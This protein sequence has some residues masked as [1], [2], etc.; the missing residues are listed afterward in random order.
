MG[1]HLHLP[2]TDKLKVVNGCHYLA[3][4]NLGGHKFFSFVVYKGG[5]RFAQDDGPSVDIGDIDILF[6]NPTDGHVQRDAS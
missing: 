1:K 6:V 4:I 5:G 2:S 3:S